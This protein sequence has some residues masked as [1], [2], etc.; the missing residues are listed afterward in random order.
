MPKKV[1][2]K[3]L[4][5]WGIYR[6]IQKKLPTILIVGSFKNIFIYSQLLTYE[7]LSL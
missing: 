1:T 3:V 6:S 7:K 5:V 2:A 4:P